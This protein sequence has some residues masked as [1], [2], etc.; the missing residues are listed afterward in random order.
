MTRGA[1]P[2]IGAVA[3]LVLAGAVHASAATQ[4]LDAS[5]W[6]NRHGSGWKMVF[7]PTSGA[8]RFVYGRRFPAPIRATT[9]DD[10]ETAAR[11]VI[12]DHF[13]FFG[14]PATELD[15]LSVHLIPLSRVGSSDKVVVRFRQRAGHLPVFNATA[16]VLFDARSGDVLALDTTGVPFAQDVPGRPAMGAA[17]ATRIASEAFASAM[18]VGTSHVTGIEL[19]I[20]GPTPYFGLRSTLRQ[21]GPTLAYEITLASDEPQADSGLPA[22]AR[23][24]VSAEG[25]G[26]VFK[27]QP[28]VWAADITGNVK[29]NVNTG[30]EPNDSG[31][32]EQP[33]LANL[34]VRQNDASGPVLATT[35]ANGNFTIPQSGPLTL[36]FELRGPFMDVNNLGGVP[37]ASFTV[38]ASGGTPVN[39]LFNP[40][41]DEF[42]TAEVAGQY[43][44]NTLRNF[45]KTIDPTDT[46]M[47][48]SVITKVNENSSC[49]AYYD[50]SSIN[51][52]R[53]SGGCPNTAYRT[54]V[55]HEE[56]HWANEKYNGF[57]TGAFH[58]GVADGW[59]YSVAAGRTTYASAR[60]TATRRVTAASRTS[61][62]RPSPPRCGRCAH[63]SRTPSAARRAPR[64]QARCSSAGSRPSTTRPSPTSSPITGSCSTTTTAT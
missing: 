46:T 57:P 53:A 44:V 61:R 56:G 13:D 16:G 48:F 35:D 37:D 60:T 58:E 11:M 39:I 52:F 63:A 17:E 2:L 40:A 62:E 9:P 33:N 34:D 51:F 7:D 14:F 27:V 28:T 22:A 45:V 6:S 3:A 49:N 10:F 12:D 24:F 20:V 19:T 50:G 23:V 29:G 64:S 38:T 4:T 42:T 54:I 41:L 5:A 47:D 55:H 26:E 30:S 1:G 43:W 36:F 18:G 32:Q 31:N 59:A 25:D 8:P 15:V 21:R